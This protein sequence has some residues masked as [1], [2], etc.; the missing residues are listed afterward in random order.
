MAAL[1][2]DRVWAGAPPSS[3]I[4][5]VVKHGSRII[6]GSLVGIDAT[7]YAVP[8]SDTAGLRFAGIAQHG[9]TGNTSALVPVEV[10]VSLGETLH[11]VTISDVAQGDLFF[12]LSGA[13]DNAN[14]LGIDAAT[15]TGAVGFISRVHSAEL[16]DVTLFRPEIYLALAS[17]SAPQ[18]LL[19]LPD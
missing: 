1:T 19:P 18:D 3:T 17:A 12:R 6:S 7:G 11:R 13:T 15:N 8:W 5:L 14:D 16:V 10:R 4:A 2:S 9:A